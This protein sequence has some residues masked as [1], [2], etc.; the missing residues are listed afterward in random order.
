[1]GASCPWPIE[2]V[3]PREDGRS[4]LAQEAQVVSVK[5]TQVFDAVPQ[6]G[7]ALDA[8]AR[9][10][11][12]I[13]VR[14]VADAAQPVGVHQPGAA[15]LEPAFPAAGTAALAVAD[16]AVDGDFGARLDVGEEV[17]AEA[18]LALLAE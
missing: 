10:E 6:H 16:A 17:A 8:E 7:D 2:F 15:D 3:C 9:R 18:H 5:E 11:T 12:R 1:M 4:K 14:V 13:T